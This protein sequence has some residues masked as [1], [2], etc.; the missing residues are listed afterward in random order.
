MFKLGGELIENA[1]MLVHASAAAYESDPA[2][3][4][5]WDKLGLDRVETFPTSEFT[6]DEHL[7]STNGFVANNME[8]LVIAFRGSDDVYDLAINIAAGQDDSIENYEGGVHRGF[9][10]ALEGVWIE[11]DELVKSFH[12]PSHKV[13][14][15]GHSLGGALA[16][17][18]AKRLHSFVD[19]VECITFGQPRVG[20]PHFFQ[21]YKVKHHR[22]VNE[23]DMIPKLPPR[24]I[25]TRYWH[26]GDEELMDAA[27]NIA[28][29]DGDTSLLEDVFFG[30]LARS[31]DLTSSTNEG[32][33][34]QLIKKGLEDHSMQTYVKRLMELAITS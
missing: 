28:S 17:L 21:N 7:G 32:F 34:D 13:W 8:H 30:R 1:L 2:T 15:T 3:Y 18:T 22:Y 14:I 10:Q 29:G 6:A 24:G 23:H 11:L 19:D 9:M 33:L 4:E 16:T 5:H 20:D 31:F 25:F 27:G 26:V 12:L